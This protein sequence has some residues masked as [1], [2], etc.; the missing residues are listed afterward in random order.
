MGN[1]TRKRRSGN[2]T[3]K[4]ASGNITFRKKKRTGTLRKTGKRVNRVT[5]KRKKGGDDESKKNIAFNRLIYDTGL[6]KQ[7]T[8]Y[9]TLAKENYFDEEKIKEANAAIVK[10]F[11]QN[12]SKITL[13]APVQSGG[14]EPSF[15]DKVDKYSKTYTD[16]GNTGLTKTNGYDPLKPGQYYDFTQTQFNKAPEKPSPKTLSATHV[17]SVV[18]KENPVQ[19]EETVDI[20]TKLDNFYKSQLT[21]VFDKIENYDRLIEILRFDKNNK[22]LVDKLEN[23]KM[24][25]DGTTTKYIPPPPVDKTQLNETGDVQYFINSFYK[26]DKKTDIDRDALFDAIFKNDKYN[27]KKDAIIDVLLQGNTYVEL[28]KSTDDKSIPCQIIKKI[29]DR[30]NEVYKQQEGNYVLKNIDINNN[31]DAPF[32]YFINTHSRVNNSYP[33]DF[34]F[35]E[36]QRIIKDICDNVFKVKNALIKQKAKKPNAEETRAEE[37]QTNAEEKGKEAEETQTNAEETETKADENPPIEPVKPKKQVTDPNIEKKTFELKKSKYVPLIKKNKATSSSTG[38]NINPFARKTG[39]T[40]G[41]T[42]QLSIPSTNESY[43]LD[44]N[45]NTDETSTN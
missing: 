8:I 16:T 37:T 14:T 24:K 6:N 15:Q 36:I 33:V 44:E 41:I 10:N 7:L 31:V 34:V 13:A 25:Y 11:I 17:K 32:L 18:P 9:N 19:K 40:T 30:I 38:S 4:R 45:W 29:K 1:K 26:D 35:N 20:K 23:E 39:I 2:K 5:H 12:Y 21:E 43:T 3:Q 28:F 27:A 22:I 42:P